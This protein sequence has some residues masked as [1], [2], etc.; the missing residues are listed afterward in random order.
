M[1]HEGHYKFFLKFCERTSRIMNL[2]GDILEEESDKHN[3]CLELFTGHAYEQYT[4]AVTNI[5]GK[6]NNVT[7]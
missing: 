5:Q 4:T 1:D 7:K 2:L 3:F 6:K